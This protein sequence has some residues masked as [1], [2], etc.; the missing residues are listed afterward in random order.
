MPLGL[1][2]SHPAYLILSCSGSEAF[3]IMRDAMGESNFQVFLSH[4]SKDKPEVRQL[5]KTLRE[6]G[7]KVWLDEDEFVPGDSWQPALAK[8]IA[9]SATFAVCL[10][11]SGIGPWEDEEM[12]GALALAVQEGKRVIPIV[13]PSAPKKPELSLFLARDPRS[14]LGP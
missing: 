12:Q 8:A 9:N 1:S 3:G 14:N 13:L 6:R 4:N 2:L 10:G 7:I 5:A 11:S